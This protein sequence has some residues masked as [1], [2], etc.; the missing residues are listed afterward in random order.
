MEFQSVLGNIAKTWCAKRGMIL[1]KY[2]ST[3]DRRAL[4]RCVVQLRSQRRLLQSPAEACQLISALRATSHLDGDIAEVGTAFGGSARL[5][6]EYSGNKT[7]HLC[8]TFQGLPKPGDLDDKFS[9]GSY[10]C[11]LEDVRQY[12]QGRRVEFHK[13]LFPGSATSLQ[14]HRF[15]FV[16]LDVDLYQS[17]LD[18]L[19][20]FYPRLNPGGIIITHDYSWAAGVDRA[21]SEFFTDKPEKPIETIGYQ[22]MVVKLS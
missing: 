6:S 3:D 12:L 21:F 9:E 13:G 22:A 14:G 11:S 7:I 2:E 20:F 17:T 10:R 4:L 16:H 18:C 19:R 5:I 1:A 8:D 15:S